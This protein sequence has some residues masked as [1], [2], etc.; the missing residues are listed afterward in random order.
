[1][2][3]EITYPTHNTLTFTGK[4]LKPYFAKSINDM[5]YEVT[6]LDGAY[7]Y[8]VRDNNTIFKIYP[9]SFEFGDDLNE[10]KFHITIYK[11]IYERVVSQHPESLDD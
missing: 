5:M 3:N 8:D 6:G 11:E 10:F 7:L 9:Q 1:M 4:K 2:F